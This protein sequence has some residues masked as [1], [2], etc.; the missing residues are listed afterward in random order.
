MVFGE[1]EKQPRTRP[2]PD[3]VFSRN[4]DLNSGYLD[5]ISFL[6]LMVQ[7]SGDQHLGCLKP[8]V[9]NGI[10][11]LVPTGDRRTSE[12]STVLTTFV[13]FKRGPQFHFHNSPWNLAEKHIFYAK[14]SPMRCKEFLYLVV[15]AIV[16]C[17]RFAICFQRCSKIKTDHKLVNIVSTCLNNQK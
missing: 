10:N 13:E 5:R 7:N 15:E 4:P 9:N 2:P 17:L 16:Q 11:Y 3:T 1:E 6:L 14:P 12:P 8:V